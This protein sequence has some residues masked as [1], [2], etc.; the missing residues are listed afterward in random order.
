MKKALLLLFLLAGGIVFYLLLP[1]NGYN[2]QA[3]TDPKSEQIKKQ[4]LAAQTPADSSSPNIIIILADDLSK[5][6][7]SLYGKGQVNTPNI[8]SLAAEGVKFSQ[9]YVSAPVCSPSR[10]GLV[11]GRYQQRFGYE[12]QILGSYL[13]NRLQYL[14]FTHLINMGNVKVNN[15]PPN[16]F[17]GKESIANMGVPTSEI[18]LPEFLKAK[19]YRTSIYGKWHLGYEKPL[20]PLQRGFEHHYG[21]Y[22]AF[23]AYGHEDDSSL[24]NYH[25]DEF[26]DKHIWENSRKGP[27]QIRDDEKIVDDKEYL[28]DKIT[29]KAIQFISENKNK[30]F[31]LYLPYNA[32]HTP[33]QAKKSDYDF[34]RDIKEPN[35]R[36]YFAIIKSLDDAIGRINNALKKE[37]LE[38]NTIVFFLSDNGGATYTEVSDNHPLKGGK[39][40]H[41]EGGINVPMTL[42]WP[43]KIQ[44]NTSYDLPVSALDIFGTVAAATNIKL[45]ADRVYDGVNLLPFVNKE[46][47]GEPHKALFWKVGRN[48]AIRN[49]NW[50]LIISEADKKE[51]L[52]N[53]ATDPYEQKNLASSQS[54]KLQELKTALNNWEKQLPQPRWTGITHFEFDFSDGPYN[55]DI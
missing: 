25:Q 43:A 7:I 17:P 39:F 9:A 55:V 32:P 15:L 13:K 18:L 16:K 54:G 29:D 19:H 50:K 5:Y 8:D 34:F 45:P 22:E 26:T 2:V 46:T 36:I 42:K 53:L 28:T 30:P 4:I 41:F 40:S 21:F 35:R 33:F 10:A 49:G 31:F 23:S 20:L 38:K 24:V 12:Y 48:S 44:P 11:T 1:V 3:P 14:A 51:Y 47:A 37:G 52:Y 6:D 27:S